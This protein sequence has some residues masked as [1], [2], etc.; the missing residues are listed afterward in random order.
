MDKLTIKGL[1]AECIIGVKPKERKIKQP[2][3]LDI[4]LYLDLKKPGASDN[5]DDSID[6][7][8]FS[9]RIVDFVEKS[10]FN[11]IE[12]LATQVAGQAKKLSQAKKI[13][14]VI[15]KPQALKTAD[16]V[17]VETML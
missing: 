2:V 3:I 11:L 9:D 12:K 8:I 5:L 1:R 4:T 13:K 10:R 14:V 6:Y 15:Y 7:Q 16:Y 17:S